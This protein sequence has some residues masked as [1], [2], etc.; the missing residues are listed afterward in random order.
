MHQITVTA[1]ALAEL[2]DNLSE[3]IAVFKLDKLKQ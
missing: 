3:K 2:A 1:K